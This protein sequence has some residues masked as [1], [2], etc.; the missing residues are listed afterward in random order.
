MNSQKILLAGVFAL[1][2]GLTALAQSRDPAS[3]IT[4]T[5]ESLVKSPQHSWARPIIF[6]DALASMPEEKIQRIDRKR[7]HKMQLET[8]G[9][10]WIP[11]AMLADF[12]KLTVGQLYSFAGTVDQIKGKFYVMVDG[13]Y[14]MYTTS[15]MEAHWVDILHEPTAADADAQATATMQALLL[16]VQTSLVRQAE[17]MGM[18]VPQ[19]L[20]AESQGG[21]RI[22][23][24]A[25]AD[26][27]RT[28]LVSKNQTADQ[29]MVSSVLAMLQKEM[30]LAG[31]RQV[32]EAAL[33]EW[34]SAPEPVIEEVAAGVEVEM[35]PDI[36]VADDVLAALDIPEDEA[37]FTEDEADGWA[38]TDVTAE[39]EA[40]FA[41][42]DDEPEAVDV[43]GLHDAVADPIEAARDEA[44]EAADEWTDEAGDEMPWLDAGEQAG[45][46]EVVAETE[47][48]DDE[49]AAV[50]SAW[51]EEAAAEEDVLPLAW[52]DDVY[53]EAFDAMAEETPPVDAGWDADELMIQ[54]LTAEEIPDEYHAWRAV[55][56]ED[57]GVPAVDPVVALA[58]DVEIIPAVSVEPTR[59]EL[60]RK[61]EEE[62]ERERLALQEAERLAEATKQL[63]KERL[64]EEKKR[65]R[66][67]AAEEKRLAKL[68]AAEEKRVA[69]EARAAAREAERLAKEE[70]ARIAAEQD[71]AA[72]ATKEELARLRAERLLAEREAERV[73]AEQAAE[74]ARVAREQEAARLA[75]EEKTLLETAAAEAEMQRQLAAE[76]AR[77]DVER[78]EAARIA[79]RNRM[80][81][82][83]NAAIER[84]RLALVEFLQDLEVR[85]AAAEAEK[86]KQEAELKRIQAAADAEARKLAQ[87]RQA[88]AEARFEAE[89]ARQEA[90]RATI[91]VAMAEAEASI[92]ATEQQM[93]ENAEALRVA[94]GRRATLETDIQKADAPQK[95]PDVVPVVAVPG[96][97][98]IQP[99]APVVE[100]RR[101]W[102]GRG[103]SDKQP[104]KPKPAPP[105]PAIKPAPPA[106][107]VPEWAKPMAF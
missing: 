65:E 28:E 2:I 35:V 17:E 80:L 7:Y 21:Q 32:A 53:G 36:A 56:S 44:P 82:E 9:D 40:L 49:W 77:L 39:D 26:A 94:Q 5:A 89:I 6:P 59:E 87:E 58:D 41:A 22:A 76:A 86:Q 92:A 4:V 51:D 99:P 43:A 15:D 42:P 63:E 54:A 37:V 107:D 24:H 97:R 67:R 20:N 25:V 104:P 61:A 73:A 66:E 106:G 52:E 11:E 98:D 50:E 18:T 3:F 103:E 47:V 38:E 19:F 79:E 85:K 101:G 78:R 64:A 95:V 68:R 84:E 48:A 88:E 71:A 83:E 45:V 29:L 74:A 81:E 60:L 72:Q 69:A 90:E 96:S 91:Q 102:F 57:A 55:I 12:Q 8:A 75:A 105:A 34:V 46:P 27:L 10:V 93:A 16:A 70:A 31:S 23:E 100:K 1:A 62:R 30:L 13:C 33:P 14:R